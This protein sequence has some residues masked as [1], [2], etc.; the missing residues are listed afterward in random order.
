MLKT[1]YRAGLKVRTPRGDAA[2]L[3]LQI[4]ISDNGTGVPDD[5]RQHIFEP[6]V[7]SKATGSGLGLALVSKIIA[8]HGGVISCDSAPGYT[9]FRL[10]LPV[11]S[12]AEL[13]ADT[14]GQEDAA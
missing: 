12:A 1:A 7:T 14:A 5:L 3:P 2:S 6:F 11:A 13:D 9:S 10:L 8:D 4:T